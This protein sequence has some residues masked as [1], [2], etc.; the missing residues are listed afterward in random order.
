MVDAKLLIEK[1]ENYWKEFEQKLHFFEKIR[2]YSSLEKIKIFAF[3]NKTLTDDELNTIG[4]LA[5]DLYFIPLDKDYVSR[6]IFTIIPDLHPADDNLFSDG[7]VF[8]DHIKA[9]TTIKINEISEAGLCMIYNRNLD[10][11]DF[12]EFHF[13]T[14]D[15]MNSH[16]LI[17]RC[18]YFE[19][20]QKEFKNYF[21]FF[22][23]QDYDCKR[24]R[25]W[26]RETYVQTKKSS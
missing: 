26:I 22:G 14:E 5:D 17:A 9:I 20:D 24:I 6:K 18:M 23:M 19:K 10:H 2:G 11:G 3:T 4:L 13:L 1:G 12:R 21:T 8:Q 16:V 7:I 25:V 15:E